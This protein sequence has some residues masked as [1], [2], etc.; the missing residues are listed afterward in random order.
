MMATGMKSHK[1]IVL[2]TMLQYILVPQMLGTMVWTQTVTVYLILTKMVT[3]L[4]LRTLVVQIVM[5]PMLQC[6]LGIQK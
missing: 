4:I 6:I 1:E 2:M 5:I 3:V